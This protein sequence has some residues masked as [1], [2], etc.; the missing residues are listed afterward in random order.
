MLKVSLELS[1]IWVKEWHE[2]MEWSC[3]KTLRN[4]LS[5]GNLDFSSRLLTFLI[6]WWL[7]FIFLNVLMKFNPWNVMLTKK[8]KFDFLVCNW[9]FFPFANPKPKLMY[10]CC[11]LDVIEDLVRKSLRNERANFGVQQMAYISPSL[12]TL[13]HLSEWNL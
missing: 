9:P 8:S 11:K 10:Q 3:I 12:K 4:F 6:S 7:S 1:C 13:R 2:V 5:L